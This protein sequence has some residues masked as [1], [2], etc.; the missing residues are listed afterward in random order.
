MSEVKYE[1]KIVSTPSSVESVYRV[2]SNMQNLERMKELIPQDRVQEIEFQEDSARFKLDGLGQKLSIRIIAKEENDY[3]KYG[4]E[5]APVDGN[6]WIQ[7][8]PASEHETFIRLTVKLD[9][10]LM[11]RT[12]MSS[13][14]QGWIDQAAEMIAKIPFEEWK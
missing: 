8:K 4:V 10:P 14:A 13:K 12:I 11:F 3:V 5:D 9:L 6:C 2:C 1:S 7:F